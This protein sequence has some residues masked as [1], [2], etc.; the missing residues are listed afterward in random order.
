MPPSHRAWCIVYDLCIRSQHW[1]KLSG[2]MLTNA[3]HCFN[4][5][6][7]LNCPV[8][9]EAGTYFSRTFPIVSHCLFIVQM[10]PIIQRGSRKG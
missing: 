6:L 3:M 10:N 7:S 5:S 1:M 2:Y 9:V 4:R 8:I